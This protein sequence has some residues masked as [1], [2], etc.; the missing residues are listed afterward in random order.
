VTVQLAH[1]ELVVTAHDKPTDRRR[2]NGEPMASKEASDALH[3]AVDAFN[4]AL[5]RAG[6]DIAHL[7]YGVAAEKVEA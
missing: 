7:G 1:F 6:F 3:L 5:K 4:D 2:W